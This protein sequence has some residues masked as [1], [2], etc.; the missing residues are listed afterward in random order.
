MIHSC[1]W[2]ATLNHV[3]ESQPANSVTSERIPAE[4]LAAFDRVA[5]FAGWGHLVRRAL[6]DRADSGSEVVAVPQR[7]HLHAEDRS[8]GKA[9]C[10]NPLLR[11]SRSAGHLDTPGDRFSIGA[12]HRF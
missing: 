4:N 8:G 6:C 11:D 5:M 3:C 2:I 1:D 12:A 9:L 7:I 10:R